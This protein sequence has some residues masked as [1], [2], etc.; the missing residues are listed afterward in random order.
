MLSA[1]SF[2]GIF[3]GKSVYSMLNALKMFLKRA[4]VYS[5]VV[6]FIVLKSTINSF[7]LTFITLSANSADDK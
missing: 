6:G 3:M 1:T 2:N 7:P 4:A 5:H